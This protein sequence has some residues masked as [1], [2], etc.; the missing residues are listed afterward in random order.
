[1]PINLADLTFEQRLRL[2]EADA[3]ATIEMQKGRGVQVST[4][5]DW[6][7]H[8]PTE[9]QKLFLDLDCKE[10][11]YGGAAGGGKALAVDTPIATPFGWSTM[12]ELTVGAQVIGDDGKPCS[13]VAVSPI[14]CEKTYQVTFSD[15][16]QIVAGG[17]HKWRTS[18]LQERTHLLRA[19]PEFRAQ[20]RAGRP[21]RSK[22]KRPDVA[23]KNKYKSEPEALPL[24]GIRTTLEIH[25]TLKVRGRINH[26]VE[27]AP[28]LVLPEVDLPIDPYVLGAWLGDGSSAAGAI[29]GL[30]E[31]IFEQ[32]ANGGYV[33][34]RHANRYSRG[35]IGLRP[36]LR[37]LGVLGNKHIPVCYLR[38]SAPQRL[39]LLQGVMDT[40]GSC[41]L[42]G[43]CEITLTRKELAEDVHE[44]ILSLGAKCAF[45]E[46]E[47][48]L[49]GR[50]ISPRYRLKFIMPAPA[51]RLP[52][53]L[54]RQKR[55]GFR[56]THNRRYIVSIELID[57]VPLKCIQVDSPSHLYLAGRQMI[58][59]HNSDAVL[60]A[61]LQYVHIPNYA[62]IIFRRSYTDLTLPEALMSRAREWLTGK[63]QWID[64][65][66][67]WR[68]PSGATLTF[69]YLETEND[70]YRY[71]GSAYQFVG[72]DELTQFTE[73]QYTYLFSRLRRLS[74]SSIP[75]RMRAASNPGGVGARWV[76]ERFVPDDF[77]PE[78][79]ES[80][81]VFWT[82]SINADNKAVRRAFIP[83]RLDDNPH[84]D[85]AEYVE[86]LNEL[87]AVTREQL[88][89][90]DWQIRERGNVYPMWED[91]LNGRHV[92]TWSQFERV[93]GVRHIP[94]HWLGAHGHDPGFD[95]DPRAAVW[96][97]VAGANSQLA[98]DVFCVRELYANRMT[99]DDFAAEVKRLEA[100]LS[101]AHRIRVRVIGHEA[102]SEQAT[103]SQ[104]H[105]L[106]YTKVRPD[107]NGGIAQMRHYLR[108]TDFDKPHPFKPHIASCQNSLCQGCLM[109]RPH[110]YVVVEDRGLTNSRTEKDMVNFR[111]EMAAYRYID[112]SPSALRGSPKVVP[113]DFFNHLMDAQRN[114]AVKWF[115][116]TAALKDEERIEAKMQ[117]GVRKV[118]IPEIKTKEDRDRAVQSNEF[119]TR[120]FKAEQDKEK[121]KSL[122]RVVFRK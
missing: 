92:I 99:V 31:E 77:T 29:A 54:V 81:V 91:G 74:E 113:Y 40:D 7:P 75:I 61:A 117:I 94:T 108:I 71:Q 68:F 89:K 104:K 19:T 50:Y 86:S 101:E 16:S 22:G 95:P 14:H 120:H 62:A 18:T 23:E 43:Q 121:S 79:A 58:P 46:G 52:R 102:S 53:K 47:A 25:K 85:R 15:G 80:A 65:E 110:F 2:A 97:F 118:D 27:V 30:D 98:G 84:L 36:Q 13:V 28:P 21:T 17:S 112:A 106:S 119:W 32:V 9:R 107:A 72:F 115:A 76:Q 109:G 35:I 67:T 1:M 42:R 122:R 90:G 8:K 111:A 26:S 24:W 116:N 48:K 10:A 73:T 33:V 70:K 56:G 57:S 12:G 83:A 44:L 78:M 51:F 93:F 82:E 20:R 63:A 60:M 88:L 38:S 41:D 66:K 45:R 96:N 34:T 87:D 4:K 49:N 69:G 64:K 105:K 100:P 103:L 6:I 5:K 39:A 114:I 55:A 37:V 11:F 59:T 3:L